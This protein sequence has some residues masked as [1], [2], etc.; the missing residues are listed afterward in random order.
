[1]SHSTFRPCLMAWLAFAFGSV[2]LAQ[3]APNA[4]RPPPPAETAP[5]A[6]PQTP[7]AAAEAPQGVNPF[8]QTRIIDLSAAEAARPDE[9]QSVIARLSRTMNKKFVVDP[10]VRVRLG[11]LAADEID[12]NLLKTLLRVQ[13]T[14]VVETED[15]VLIVPDGNARYLPTPILE[16]DDNDIHGATWVTRVVTVTNFDASMLAGILRPMLHQQALLSVLP[17]NRVIIVDR[18]DNVKRVADVIRVLDRR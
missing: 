13:E 6:G 3:P 12:F 1:M 8:V 16:G 4:Q 7:S 14:T 5:A 18:Y 2:A 15:A 11:S 10:Q 9:L 17:P